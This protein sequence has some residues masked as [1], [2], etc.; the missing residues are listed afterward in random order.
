M[1]FLE[2]ILISAFLFTIG[3]PV[4]NV[5]E[6]AEPVMLATG[7]TVTIN[8]TWNRDNTLS[9]ANVEVGTCENKGE[10]ITLYLD[11]IGNIEEVEIHNGIAISG[12]DIQVTNNGNQYI[13]TY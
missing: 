4:E 11:E 8:G 9:T 1:N 5:Q 3:G 6:Q 12:G 7:T 10:C 13:I 2:S